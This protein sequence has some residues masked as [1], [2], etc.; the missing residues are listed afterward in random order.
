M[1]AT[2]LPAPSRNPLWAALLLLAA[3][4]CSGESG[5]TPNDE[6]GSGPDA[7]TE[8]CR[9]PD[10]R[11]AES[12]H[13]FERLTGTVVDETGAGIAGLRAQACGLNLCINSDAAA[14]GS[15]F[16]EADAQLD[17]GAFKYGLGRSYVKFAYPMPTDAVMD[18]G[19]H[20]TV[21]LPDP[22]TGAALVAGQDA[23]SGS[24]ALSLSPD[25]AEL[26][27]DPFDFDEDALKLF[28]AAE[29]PAANA[30]PA[31]DP[32]LGLERIFGM[33]P[34]GT[35]LCPAAKM[36]IENTT[37]LAPGTRVEVFLHGVEVSEEWAPY[38]GWAHVSDGAVSDDG[39]TISTDEEGGIPI[40]SVVGIR[41]AQN[42]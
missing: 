12:L 20:G 41:K 36:T 15:V 17:N 37:D 10:S 18:V 39:A 25:M 3:P 28:R 29:I 4:A 14:D 40:L 31:V 9:G 16:I 13:P 33:T 2:P 24:V 23:S 22:E 32:A 26:E 35:V 8:E 5:G 30:P 27:I 1:R 34:V 11:S 38:G 6:P 7:A 42:P 19:V 21:R